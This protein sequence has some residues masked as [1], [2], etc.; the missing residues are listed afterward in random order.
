MHELT[1]RVTSDTLNGFNR[2]IRETL[3]DNAIREWLEEKADKIKKE[4]IHFKAGNNPHKLCSFDNTIIDKV[5]C[6]TEKTLEE[7]FAKAVLGNIPNTDSVYFT[8]IQ[9]ILME[10]I[11]PLAQIAKE[12][13]ERGEQ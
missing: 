11:K 13:Y 6:L 7:K 12:H 2:A 9:S 3:V 1:E 4:C 5:L 8:S 10:K